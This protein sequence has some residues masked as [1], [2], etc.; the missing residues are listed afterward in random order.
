VIAFLDSAYYDDVRR[1]K[2]R[3]ENP[4][5]E[6]V[7]EVQNQLVGLLDVEYEHE[8][9]SITFPGTEVKRTDR[10][11]VIHHLAVHPHFRRQC[12][13]SRLL[14][15]ILTE[16]QEHEVAFIEAWTRD[17]EGACLWYEGHGFNLAHRYLHVYASDTAE[18]TALI[19]EGQTGV[20][21]VSVFAHYD[22]DRPDLVRNRFTRVHECRLYRRDV[23]SR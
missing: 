3:Y 11:S 14:E 4:A 2:E 18:A 12:I 13:G 22:G 17:D 20:T 6:I 5:I 15:A 16:L 10:G 21:P 9:G 7:A 23:S 8:P 1:C 19:G